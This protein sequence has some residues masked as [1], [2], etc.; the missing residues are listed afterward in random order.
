MLADHLDQ[1]SCVHVA[2][3]KDKVIGYSVNSCCYQKTPFYKKEIPLFY[4]RHLFLDP[5]VQHQAVGLGLQTAGL[6]YQL[7]PF[8][9]F[10]RFAVTFLTS[11]PQVIRILSL[12]NEYY[13][14]LDGALP[15]KVYAFCQQLG[16]MMGFSRVDRR[17]LVYGTNETILDGED[18]TSRWINFISSGHEKYDQM[19][20]NTVF[21][22]ED[23]KIIHTGALLVAIGYARP[24]HFFRRFLESR[25]RYRR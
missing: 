11:N 20:L 24:L 18:Y 23:G 8:W 6:R 22:S 13:P 14:R 5:S 2:E 12:Y 4:Q 16:S 19:L 3:Q 9:L 15:D 21:R 7:G 25:F 17:L 1:D 10:R